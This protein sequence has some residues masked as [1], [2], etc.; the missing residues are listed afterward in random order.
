MI[1]F[2]P[3]RVHVDQ[4]RVVIDDQHHGIGIRIEMLIAPCSERFECGLKLATGVGQF[5]L[6]P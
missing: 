5:V 6:D 2:E 4:P 1:G 3:A